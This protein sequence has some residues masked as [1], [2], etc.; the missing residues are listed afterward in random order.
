MKKKRHSLKDIAFSLEVSVTTVSFVLSGKGKEKGI[1]D[2]VIQKVL[3]HAEK[4]GYK[5]NEVARSLRTG[6]S[7]IIVCMVEDIS[8]VFFAQIARFIEDI[9]YD[10]GYKV[11][12]CSN[13]NND[14]KAIELISLFRER[15]V[16]GY[17]ITPTSGIGDTINSILDANI[18]V[19]LFDR[20]LPDVET[21]HVIVDNDYS[22]YNSTKH[23]LS[24]HFKNIALVTTDVEQTSISD[25]INGYKRALEEYKQKEHILSVP[26]KLKSSQKKKEIIRDFFFRKP[27]LDAVL[28][29]TN[30]LTLA[31][32]EVLKKDFPGLIY[33]WGIITFDDNIFFEIHTPS[34]SAVS[35]P[36]Q[37]MAEELM[38]ILL[39][40]L[41]SR[42]GDVAVKKEVFQAALEVR[43]SSLLK[44]KR[45]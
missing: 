11:L 15:Q 20:Y 24:N 17:I 21:S 37:E 2:A 7:K 43:N 31:G 35:Q 12:F 4:I 23:L 14:E 8:N 36:L 18:P 9:A 42:S 44:S 34:I 16:D 40:S 33:K 38:A 30:Y 26:Y 27:E 1:S 41:R 45:T 10:K 13:D 6:E 32:L 5:P 19:V 29:S 22:S 28:F 3:S 39:N 25:R